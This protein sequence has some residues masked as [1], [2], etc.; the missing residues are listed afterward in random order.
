MTH[1]ELKHGDRIRY[2]SYPLNLIIDGEVGTN[3]VITC[4]NEE[5]TIR[6]LGKRRFSWKRIEIIGLGKE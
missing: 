2:R 1:A 6:G 3:C 5:V 4:G